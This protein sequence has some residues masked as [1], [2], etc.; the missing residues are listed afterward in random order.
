MPLLE[1][2][3]IFILVLEKRGSEKIKIFIL[4]KDT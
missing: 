4:S 3:L 2:Q 1:K